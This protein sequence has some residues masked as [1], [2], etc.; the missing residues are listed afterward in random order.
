M[1]G[2]FHPFPQYTYFHLMNILAEL[3]ELYERVYLEAPVNLPLKH[4]LDLL[5]HMPEVQ[6]YKKFLV[7]IASLTGLKWDWTFLIKKKE[8]ERSKEER[9]KWELFLYLWLLTCKLLGLMILKYAAVPWNAAI[10]NLRFHSK[11]LTSLW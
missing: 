9:F 7:T 11:N 8:E 3:Y 10:S 1:R 5:V 2:R 6:K 4:L